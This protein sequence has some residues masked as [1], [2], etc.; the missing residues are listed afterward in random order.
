MKKLIISILVVVFTVSLVA[1]D[2]NLPTPKKTGGKPLMDCLAERKS[3]KSFDGDKSI[4]MQTLSSLLW[5]AWG[6]NREE[7]RTAPSSRN[8]Q[9]IDIYVA[10]PSGMYLWD[11]KENVLKLIVKKDLRKATGKQDYVEKA[12]VN[13]VYVCNIERCATKGD[14]QKLTESTYANAGFVSQNVYL[15]CA[16]EG[17]GTV[18]R[19]YVDKELLSKEMNLTSDQMVVLC[20]SVGY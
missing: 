18:V 14:T 7:K 15:F 13:L 9:E 6:F 12:A 3:T 1:Q 17:L 20:Q 16:S 10:L 11:A 19:G 4:D 5:A 2:I 8:K